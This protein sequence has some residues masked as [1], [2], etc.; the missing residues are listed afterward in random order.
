MSCQSLLISGTDTGV[1]KT[2]VTAALAMALDSVGLRVAPMKPV[3]TGCVATAAGLAPCDALFLRRIARCTAALD[4]ICPYRF[5]PPVAPLVAAEEA[6]E[7]IRLAHLT[8]CRQR[9]ADRAD[10]LLVEGAGGLAV[11]L[12]AD[13]DYARLARRWRLPLLLVIDNRLGCLNHAR[14][15]VAYA[16]RVGLSILG[17]VLNQTQPA[18]GE[19][20]RSN[21]ASLA[22]LLAV[23]CLGVLPHVGGAALSPERVRALALGEEGE[24]PSATV[25][26]TLEAIRALSQCLS[27]AA[28]QHALARD[29]AVKQ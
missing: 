27:L 23:P 24:P 9:L 10:V 3:E 5:A 8:A 18:A 28:L 16:E 22:R 4:L 2:I 20:A 11:P 29:A 19:A 17:Y 26:T 21:P 1:G 14:L 12:R 15:S 13:L 25:A 7:A 6:G